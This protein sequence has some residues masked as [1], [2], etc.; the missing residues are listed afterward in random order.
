MSLERKG[1]LSMWWLAAIWTIIMLKKWFKITSSEGKIRQRIDKL[2][3]KL[4]IKKILAFK[5]AQYKTYM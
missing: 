2:R 4:V 5:N 3:G 1:T